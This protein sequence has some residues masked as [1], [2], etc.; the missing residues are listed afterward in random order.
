MYQIFCEQEPLF[1]A[2]ISSDQHSAVCSIPFQTLRIGKKRHFIKY[3]DT[4]IIKGG[5]RAAAPTPKLI[6]KKKTR[7]L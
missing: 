3:R 6:F 5:F 2:E 7:I 1:V 4:E